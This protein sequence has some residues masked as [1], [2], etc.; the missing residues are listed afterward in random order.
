MEEKTIEKIYGKGGPAEGWRL[1]TVRGLGRVPNAV[2]E[3]HRPFRGLG[4]V[5]GAGNH[6][7]T[8]KLLK[9]IRPQNENFLKKIWKK[10]WKKLWTIFGKTMGKSH[11][12]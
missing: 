7:K 8:E 4:W 3:A 5:V 1:A 12:L 2:R 11:F 9:D 10:I 6:G